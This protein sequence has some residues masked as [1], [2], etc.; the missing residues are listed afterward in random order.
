PETPGFEAVFAI[1]AMSAIAYAL[2]RRRR[3]RR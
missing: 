1:A 3:E 2:G